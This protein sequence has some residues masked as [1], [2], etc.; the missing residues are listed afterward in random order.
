M[1]LYRI[2]S[3]R[4]AF[5]KIVAVLICFLFGSSST[6]FAYPV[7]FIFKEELEKQYRKESVLVI[8]A[9]LEI[10]KKEY[11]DSD[12]FSIQDKKRISEDVFLAESDLFGGSVV[13]TVR[14]LV[15]F[16]DVKHVAGDAAGLQGLHW[17]YQ[18]NAVAFCSVYP[19]DLLQGNR[20]R[21]YIKEIRNQRAYDVKLLL[22]PAG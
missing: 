22:I 13:S 1:N 6:A 17:S 14:Y 3:P 11:F 20:Y 4:N 19:R 8:D 18:N 10:V 16:K 21:F 15:R 5:C 12:G 7:G 9:S 2:F